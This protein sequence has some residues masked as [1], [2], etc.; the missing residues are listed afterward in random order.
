MVFDPFAGVGTVGAAAAGLQR[1]F[2]LFEESFEGVD[3][4]RAALPMW[5]GVRPKS[6][7]YLNENPL[8]LMTN[9]Y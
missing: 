6:I 8:A 9:G 3:A 1:R 5:P 7:L 2:V 4:I